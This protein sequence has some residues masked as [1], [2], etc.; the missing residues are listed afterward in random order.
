EQTF[1]NLKQNKNFRRFS[2][3]G[4]KKVEVE[5]GLLAIAHNISKYCNKINPKMAI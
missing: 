4:L 3:R 1:G 5:F 2:L